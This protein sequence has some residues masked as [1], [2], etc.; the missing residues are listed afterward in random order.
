MEHLREQRVLQRLPRDVRCDGARRARDVIPPSGPLQAPYGNREGHL[1]GHCVHALEREEL[2]HGAAAP[3]AM[4]LLQ[5]LRDVL[6]RIKHDIEEQRGRV[7]GSVDPRDWDQP[8]LEDLQ[9]CR[10]KVQGL[11][12][13]GDHRQ[14]VLHH[15]RLAVV[16]SPP[17]RSS[18]WYVKCRG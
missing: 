8:V 14:E 15:K 7:G 1:R 3:V 6:Q 11:E 16:C 12:R 13:A 10:C 4:Q 2:R 18:R 5:L 9:V 17:C